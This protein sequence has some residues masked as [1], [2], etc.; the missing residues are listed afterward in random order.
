MAISRVEKSNSAYSRANTTTLTFHS[1]FLAKRETIS[2]YQSI[3]ASTKMTNNIPII[4]LLHGVYGAH[5]VW[6][7]LGGAHVVYEQL[8]QQGLKDFVLV[9]PSDGSLWD[10][11]GYLPLTHHGDFE[12]W[13]V[14]DV[15]NGVIE[16]IDGVSEQS[17]VYISGLSMGGYGALR[18]GAKYPDKF[19][20]ISAHSSVTSLNDLQQFIENPVSD[21]QC[22]F[23]QEADLSYWFKKNANLLPPLRL[24]CGKSDSLFKSNVQLCKVLDELQI[25]YKFESLEGSHEWPYWH[26]NLVK[27]LWFF[28]EI[29][30]TQVS[31]LSSA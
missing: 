4:V 9:M 12:R 29:E 2:V 8:K 26:K 22:D 24:D 1:T 28:N 31:N 5:W 16:N 14:E 7:E 27:T 23:E 21:Y 20:G 10:G 19:K 25:S 3:D 13:I 15:I 30:D 11:S 17:N 18:L 6:T